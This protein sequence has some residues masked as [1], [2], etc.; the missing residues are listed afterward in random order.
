[1]KRKKRKQP[2]HTA[3]HAIARVEAV[4]FQPDTWQRWIGARQFLDAVQPITVMDRNEATARSRYLFTHSSHVAGMLR[5]IAS[6]V[7][8]TG[9][10]LEFSIDHLID[11]RKSATLNRMSREISYKVQSKFHQWADETGLFQELYNAIIDLYTTGDSFGVMV[12]DPDN[13]ICP[14]RYLT[15]DPVRVGNPNNTINTVDQLDGINYNRYGKPTH[16]TI[17]EIPE[18]VNG[19]WNAMRYKTIPESQVC[20]IY[21]KDFSEGRRGISPLLPVLE[22]IG[23]LIDY[24]T[25]YLEQIKNQAAFIG[26]IET[27]RNAMSG[28]NLTKSAFEQALDNFNAPNNRHINRCKLPILTPGS[29]WKS[30]PN[31][32]NNIT[33]DNYV[34]TKLAA[35]AHALQ[36]PKHIAVNSAEKGSYSSIRLEQQ[37]QQVWLDTLRKIV[38]VRIHNRIF[39]YFYQ[40]ILP[41]LYEE[42][43]DEY[44]KYIPEPENVC[45]KWNYPTPEGINPKD[46][47]EMLVLALDNDLITP[48]QAVKA[49]GNSTSVTDIIDKKTEK[50][51]YRNQMAGTVETSYVDITL[52]NSIKETIKQVQAGEIME[53]QAIQLLE[54][55]YGI[56]RET[57]VS[58]ITGEDPKT[59]ETTLELTPETNTLNKSVANRTRIVMP[60]CG[61]LKQKVIA[62]LQE[63]KNRDLYF[64]DAVLVS[65]GMNNKD[66]VFLRDELWKARNTPINKPTNIEHYSNIAIG[67]ITETWATAFGSDEEIRSL[68]DLPEEFH[69]NCR[70]VIYRKLEGDLGT[71]IRDL[72]LRIE[73]DEMSVSMEVWFDDY[74][75]AFQNKDGSIEVIPRDSSNASMKKYLK[76]YRGPGEY[77]GRR[78]GRAFRGIEFIGMGFVENPANEYSE[79]LGGSF[80]ESA[81]N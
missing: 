61:T 37:R 24:E 19:S 5:N 44:F 81:L 43:I 40:W 26:F 16:Y 33:Y 64:V 46:K 49:M 6:Q 45:I 76:A 42:Y 34:Q 74:D 79:I 28:A 68:R 22:D 48:D 27:E 70:S 60:I 67:H 32:P 66:D 58:I 39:R 41:D 4:S 51:T 12:P 35:I 71:A 7:I 80:F 14:V 78:I 21:L 9:A 65:T 52:A 36:I 69:L 3:N 18:N 31:A 25:N 8:G 30:A 29:N 73:A 11:D 17:Y 54:K 59:P 10:A 72:I 13:E 47:V 77:E 75:F 23:R 2:A 15:I 55:V 53:S 38:D 63:N 62:A 57:A 50:D 20:H 56:E 1:M